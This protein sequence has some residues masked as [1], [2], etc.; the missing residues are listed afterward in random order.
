MIQAKLKSESHYSAIF[1]KS[2]DNLPG[3]EKLKNHLT[4]IT[5]SIRDSNFSHYENCR[6]G[7]VLIVTV[8][9]I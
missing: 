6:F 5:F 3:P 4:Y 9:K 7:F 1:I 8:N 2:P